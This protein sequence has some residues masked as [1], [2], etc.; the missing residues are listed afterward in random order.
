MK[1][2]LVIPAH[3]EEQ[4]IGP[5]LDDLIVCLDR[6]RIPFEIIV[7]NDNSGDATEAQVLQRARQRREIRLI[8]RP[9]PGGF[10]RAIRTGL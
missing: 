10:G 6:E 1:L 4:N 5:C 2:S 8:R 9:P 3:N 7:V